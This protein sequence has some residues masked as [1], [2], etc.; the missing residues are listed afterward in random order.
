MTGG[1]GASARVNLLL[2][3][4]LYIEARLTIFGPRYCSF[5]ELCNDF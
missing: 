4:Q 2:M 5:Q 3:T 1:G